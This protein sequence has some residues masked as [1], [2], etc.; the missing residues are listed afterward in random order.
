MAFNV[1]CPPIMIFDLHVEGLLKL[2]SKEFKDLVA[3]KYYA[4]FVVFDTEFSLGPEN[5]S[6]SSIEGTW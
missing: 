5:G 6:F 2:E 3:S 1:L 4:S